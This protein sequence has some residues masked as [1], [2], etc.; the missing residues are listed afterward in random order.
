MFDTNT[1][2]RFNKSCTDAFVNYCNAS[3][4]AYQAMA[5]QMLRMWGQSVDAFVEGAQR[6]QPGR[7]L[8]AYSSPASERGG[9]A[10]D[11]M[12]PWASIPNAM[13][14][15]PDALAAFS[16]FGQASGPNYTMFSPFA[17]WMEMMLPKNSTAWP[18]A[19]GMISFGVPEQVAWPAA[20]GNA[21]AI[22]AFGLAAKSV[23]KAFEAYGAH[24][25]QNKEPAFST[26]QYNAPEPFNVAFAV[27]PFNPGALMQFF[28][29]FRPR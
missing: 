17:S 1:Q 9:R 3:G 2:A 24:P 28:M 29:P 14:S 7:E 8:Q 25:A 10:F 11:C 27:M 16:P 20:R 21:A 4:A 22:D 23:E 6:P 26:I 13:V 5:D 19:V 12:M 15:G 18:M